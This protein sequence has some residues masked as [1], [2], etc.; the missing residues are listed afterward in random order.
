MTSAGEPFDLV[1]LAFGSIANSSKRRRLA[2]T[3]GTLQRYDLVAVRE[4][5]L[6]GCALALAQVVVLL[7]DRVARAVAH[8]LGMLALVSLHPVD[9]LPLQCHHRRRRERAT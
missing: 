5:L 7:G 9:R 1:T 2:C 3:G 6:N 4:D 8:Q